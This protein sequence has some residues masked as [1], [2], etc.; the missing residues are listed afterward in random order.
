MQYT[1]L[2]TQLGLKSEYGLYKTKSANICD[3]LRERIPTLVK[4]TFYTQNTATAIEECMLVKWFED[5]YHYLKSLDHTLYLSSPPSN[6]YIFNNHETTKI[7]NTSIKPDG[8]ILYGDLRSKG[9][10]TVHLVIEA[11]VEEGGNCTFM[12]AL[13][14]MAEYAHCIWKA[15]PTRVFVP[16]VYLYGTSIDLMLFARCGYRRVPLGDYLYNSRVVDKDRTDMVVNSIRDLWF[17]LIQPPEKFGHF[18]GVSEEA[19]YLTFEGD[20]KLTTVKRVISETEDTLEIKGRIPRTVGISLRTAYLL[21]VK[22]KGNDAVLKLAW[23]PVERQPEGALYDILQRGEVDYIPHIYRSG[24]IVSDFLGYRLEYILM[25][26]C[27]K[28]LA[29]L[30]KTDAVS[31]AKKNKL[32]SDAGHV[33]RK[34]CACLL[35][36]AKAGV[37]HRDVS[38][39]NITIRDDKVFLI[40]WG[41]GKVVSTTLSAHTKE[42]VNSDWNISLDMITRNED[43]RDGVTGTVLF[44]GIR[45]L[46]GLTSRSVFDD[47]ESILYVVLVA[48]SSIGSSKSLT[49][50]SEMGKVCHRNQALWKIGCMANSC[51]YLSNF[52]VS[53]CSNSLR[54][55]LDALR[56][57]LFVKNG[58][59]IGGKLQND[60]DDM[61]EVSEDVLRAILG[62]AIYDKCFPES[63]L[64]VSK[65]EESNSS[66]KRKFETTAITDTGSAMTSKMPRNQ[67][68]QENIDPD[69]VFRH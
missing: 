26:Y 63:R 51:N 5:I 57:M 33:I 52:G 9:I 14:Q 1:S 41:F 39:G 59:F 18:V 31:S 48:L 7:P 55:Q 17:L 12:E 22:Y 30:F 35:Q 15:Q 49:N 46:M 61:R 19:T 3:D 36:A 8:V 21:V 20:K 50:V 4:K 64:T 43:A 62:D 11:K 69:D 45:V 16:V 34:V 2:I 47:I 66:L 28:P 54:Q 58:E 37:F 53:E 10:E 24:I 23:T 67:I 60:C 13:G 32:F 6:R 27:G 40:D 38:A 42:R 25:E 44:M 65:D 68:N 29:S 56:E